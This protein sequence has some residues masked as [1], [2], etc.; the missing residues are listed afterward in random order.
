[1][2]EIYL[3]LLDRVLTPVLLMLSI[4]L[5]LRGHDQPGGGFIAGLLVS[6]AFALQILSRGAEAVRHTLGRY[7]QRTLAIGLLLAACSALYGLV[8]GEGFFHG[9]WWEIDIGPL[10]YKIGTP[11]LF[12]FGVFLGV[13]GVT[14]T[15]LLG[16]SESVIGAPPGMITS[17]PSQPPEPGEEMP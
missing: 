16:L 14:V 9:I 7:L 8:V 3:R 1:M 15:F 11:V 12:D 6:A 10:H 5:L 13:V 2:I 17:G 4:V